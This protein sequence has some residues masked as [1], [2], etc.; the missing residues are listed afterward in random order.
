MSKPRVQTQT[1]IL[2]LYE[3]HAIQLAMHNSRARF[4]IGAWGR[5]SG[6]STW[7]NNELT[8]KAWENPGHTYW[9]VSPT[10]DQAKAQY[11]R[12]VSSL[13]PCR[14]VM[15]KK[16]QTELRVKIINQAEVVFK[17]GEVFENLRGATINGV[18]IDEVREQ[19]PDLWPMIIR[20]MLATTGGW[21][22][23]ISTPNGYDQFYDLFETARMDTSGR[24][25]SFQAP[26]T[27][28]PLFTQDE[29]EASKKDMGEA[30]FDQEI[31]ANF[32]DLTSGRAYIN[33]ANEN[34]TEL[35][36]FAHA[37]SVWSPYLPIVVAMDFNLNPMSWHLGQHNGGAFH[38]GDSIHLSNS[39]TQEAA[40]ELV[41]RLL[42]IKANGHKAELTAIVIGDATG[43]AGQ[44]AAAG[45]S[46]YA[47]VF[48]ALRAAQIRF[49]DKTPESNP[50][51]VDRVN[52]L[53]AA[54]LNAAGTR[55][56]TVNPRTCPQLVEDLRRVK[57]KQGASAT[58]DSGP[59][60][61]LTH[62]SDGVGY[63]VYTLAPIK[64]YT[65]VGKLHVI[66]R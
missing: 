58:L 3:P 59:K 35:N 44:R 25:A 46:D 14:E 62:P 11:R 45:E 61:L 8:A 26:S 28:N 50:P 7:G 54:L 9:F 18:I 17:S 16:N 66:Y 30:E 52:T 23:F 49:T 48:Q 2:E 40:K 21:A 1:R 4:R 22:A 64:K 13:W 38:W 12:F 65:E 34:L 39:H 32:R 36:P 20:P 19:N 60:K 42:T 43:K 15:L 41:Q 33:F 57:W 51:V 10:F 53:N 47:I 5:Q 6:K 56:M 55:M 24:W 31:N 29:Y 37:G 63:A 27:C